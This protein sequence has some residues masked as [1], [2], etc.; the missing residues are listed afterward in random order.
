MP[1]H[2]RPGR[3]TISPGGAPGWCKTG[4]RGGAPFPRAVHR[5]GA[6]LEPGG[7]APSGDMHHLPRDRCITKTLPGRPA[8]R[9]PRP[10][11]IRA[12][13]WPLS[14]PIPFVSRRL[15]LVTSWV[16]APFLMFHV[17]CALLRPGFRGRSLRLRPNGARDAWGFPTT[18]GPRPSAARGPGGYCNLPH[19]GR[20]GY[21]Y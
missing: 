7:G 2:D 15:R 5:G 8:T 14:G 13:G 20:T 1:H 10:S 17:V 11:A 4:A 21:K 18:R 16:P 19:P 3:C 6:K 12:F 9:G